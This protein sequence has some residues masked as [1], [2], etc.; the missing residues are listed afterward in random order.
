LK[1]QPS[2]YLIKEQQAMKNKFL[3]L[4]GLCL[5]LWVGTACG[6]QTSLPAAAASVHATQPIPPLATDAKSQRTPPGCEDFLQFCVTSSIH[7]TV[8]AAATAGA[9]NSS[10]KNC[11]TWAAGGAARILE[12]PLMFAAGPDKITVAL[13]RISQY[14]G[15]GKYELLAIATKGMPDIFPTIEA[16][17]QTYSNGEGSTAVVT[18]A[19]DGSGTIQAAKLVQQA[20]IQVSN[21]DP[22]ARIDFDMQWTCQ[23][24]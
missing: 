23:N 15:P 4:V 19:A 21:P 9:N 12:L 22:S 2:P 17:G 5:I 8:T 7:G 18:I 3:Y 10:N 16:A 13:T 11:T 24:K 20:S 14:T 6:A 1:R